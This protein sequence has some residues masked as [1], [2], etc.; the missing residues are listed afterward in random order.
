[1]MVGVTISTFAIGGTLILMNN[2]LQDFP[3]VQIPLN[4]TA[5]P[6]GVHVENK[7][8]TLEGKTYTIVDAL[9]SS[10]IPD[11]NYLYDSAEKRITRQWIQGIGSEKAPAPQAKLMATVINGI[12]TRRLPWRLVLMGVALVLAV[13]LLGVRSLAFAVGSYLSIATTM[14]IFAGGAVRWLV[15]RSTKSEHGEGEAGPGA[16][17]S[18]GLIAAGGVFGLLGLACACCNSAGRN[19]PAHWRLVPSSS[20]RL[21]RATSSV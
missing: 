18:S 10:E 1:L 8:Y 3:S 4:I 9:G 6:V 7:T 2:G 16:L 11:G 17:Y 19:G 5:P 20:V 14:A 21:Y 15:E 13:E 12:L